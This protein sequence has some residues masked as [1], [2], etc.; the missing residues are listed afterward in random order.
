MSP[1]DNSAMYICQEYEVKKIRI[2]N[3][4]FGACINKRGLCFGTVRFDFTVF[5]DRGMFKNVSNTCT[6]LQI[7]SPQIPLR[8]IVGQAHFQEA[9]DF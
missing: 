7:F 3:I 4:R 8:R 2:F 6:A 9:V 5:D 1:F